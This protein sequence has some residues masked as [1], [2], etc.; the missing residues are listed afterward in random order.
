MKIYSIVFGM[1]VL[2]LLFSAEFE[3]I[4]IR[5]I[6]SQDGDQTILVQNCD[7]GGK[8]P[9]WITVKVWTP[10]PFEE[11]THAFFYYKN[12]TNDQWVQIEDCT[13]LQYGKE[14]QVFLPIYLGGRG[15]RTESLELIRATMEQSP[16]RYEATMEISVNHQ[17]TEKEKIVD[18]KTA[19]YN[20]LLA[21]AGTNSFCNSGASLCCKLKDDYESV[22][23][24]EA[25]SEALQ[26]ECQVDAAR[27]LIENAINTLNAINRDASAC[28]AAI[29]T[30]QGAESTATSRGCNSGAVRTQIDALKAQIREGTYTADVTALNS[31]MASQCGGATVPPS[32]GGTGTTGTGGTGTT[33]TGT[34]G[35]GGTG[36]GGN[37]S[38]PM[39]PGAFILFLLPLALMVYRW[40]F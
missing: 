14:C 26:K 30:V 1:L 8:E 27:I 11:T 34:G 9:T 19:T 40:D 24:L 31:A 39:C 28:S 7:P 29:A 21:E 12:F 5:R 36:A 23:G 10:N 33:G 32:T 3:D 38:K 20:T 25:R 18:N 16:T 15:D 22:T 4:Y 35:T 37:G 17:R 6:E 2:G 13:V